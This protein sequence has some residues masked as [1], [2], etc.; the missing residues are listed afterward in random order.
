[1]AKAKKST[2]PDIEAPASETPEKKPAVKVKAPKAA[3]PVAKAA[4]K[5][6]APVAP[7]VN[8]SLAAETA[9]RMI[10]AKAGGFGSPS[11]GPKKETSAFKQMKQGFT[12]PHSAGIGNMLN[13]TISPAAKKSNQP[14][15][16][17]KQVGHNQT[18]GSDASR[19]SVPRR[20]NG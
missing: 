15:H 1:M 10:G 19:T 18:M 16:A 8:T 9:A 12:K 6:A 2:T 3:K 4:A 5:T 7:M 17:D 14:F 20:T 11:T 13:S